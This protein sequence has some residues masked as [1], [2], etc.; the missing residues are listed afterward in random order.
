MK[1]WKTLALAL[2]LSVLTIVAQETPLTP[3]VLEKALLANPTGEQA[4]Q[5][6][7]RLRQTFGAQ[8]WPKMHNQI[9]FNFS[10]LF[11]D[12][13]HIENLAVPVFQPSF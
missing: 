10:M 5:L 9:Y 3:L 4:E 12:A 7:A 2:C 11:A 6:A 1:T 8:S 13:T